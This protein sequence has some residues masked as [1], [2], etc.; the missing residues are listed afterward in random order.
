MTVR[1]NLRYTKE[2]ARRE[3]AVDPHLWDIKDTELAVYV[4]Q[5]LLL[6]TANDLV[7]F[8]NK[9]DDHIKRLE[10]E[11]RNCHFFRGY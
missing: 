5:D 3:T 9:Q 2:L 6:K 8:L 4:V 7:T 11:V 10:Y 1:Q